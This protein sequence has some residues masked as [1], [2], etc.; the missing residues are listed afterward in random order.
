MLSRQ[1]NSA[2]AVLPSNWRRVTIVHAAHSGIFGRDDIWT[3]WPFS[4]RP[5][6][7]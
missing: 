6:F 5:G 2:T 1:C 4:V 7:N 3:G